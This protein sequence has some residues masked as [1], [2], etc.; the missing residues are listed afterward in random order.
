[1]KTLIVFNICGINERNNVQTY[2]DNIRSICNQ[3]ITG[4]CRVAVSACLNTVQD[5]KT[6]LKEFPGIYY[7]EIRDKMPV[8][9]TFNHTASFFYDWAD[10]VVYVDSGIR[11]DGQILEEMQKECDEKTAMISCNTSTDSGLSDWFP[12]GFPNHR[13]LMPL[14]KTHNLHVQFFNKKLWENYGKILPDLFASHCS[15][16][17]LSY[18]CAALSMDWVVRPDLMVEHNKSVDGASSGF[19]CVHPW[20]HTWHTNRTMAQ[21]MAHPDRYR[22]GM[23][24]E[25]KL[26]P[27]NLDAYTKEGYAKTLELR[28]F[29]RDNL[30]L[31]KDEFDYE[32]INSTVYGR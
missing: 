18:F 9:P 7:N 21:I 13:F 11:F 26:F 12:E 30:F 29:I 8:N 24:Y 19:Q 32:S 28:D 23:G 17:V 4:E 22:V 5:R 1:M 3:N 20:D 14:S 16:S 10:W 2:L 31:R 25:N 6:I 15:E 27:P